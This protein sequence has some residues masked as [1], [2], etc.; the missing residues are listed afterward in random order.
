MSFL[1]VEKKGRVG[2]DSSFPMNRLKSIVPTIFQQ[3]NRLSSTVSRRVFK[4]NCLKCGKEY[5]KC[6]I[7][8]I[9]CAGCGVIQDRDVVNPTYF[10]VFCMSPTFDLDEAKIKKQFIAMQ[11][12]LHPDNYVQ[13][14]NDLKSA[15]EWSSWLNRAMDTLKDSYKRAIYFFNLMSDSEY[16]EEKTLQPKSH[17]ED[18][19]ILTTIMSERMELE[20]TDDLDL[21]NEIQTYNSSNQEIVLYIY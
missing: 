14:V 21:V 7:G 5:G 12:V 20:D 1:L 16:S 2:A 10:D 13:S 3:Q 18:H 4:G 9:K 17:E 19:K 8:L 15:T 6:G 11:R